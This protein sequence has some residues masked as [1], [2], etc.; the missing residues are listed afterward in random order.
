MVKVVVLRQYQVF[1]ALPPLSL[2]CLHDHPQASSR[3]PQTL[4]E[5]VT[6][7]GDT[8]LSTFLGHTSLPTR[9]ATTGRY[10]PRGYGRPW[11]NLVLGS[12]DPLN[13]SFN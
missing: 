8:C 7:E 6:R 12:L 10:D 9:G 1:E 2:S 3:A 5:P 4:V 11:L 13:M